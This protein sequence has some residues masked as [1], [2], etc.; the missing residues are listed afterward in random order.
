MEITVVEGKYI[1]KDN[2]LLFTILDQDYGVALINKLHEMAAMSTVDRA[3]MILEKMIPLLPEGVLRKSN[4]F[5]NHLFITAKQTEENK[6]KMG[7]KH[8]CVNQTC[9]KKFYDFHKNFYCPICK[10]PLSSVAV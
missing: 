4:N 7:A 9:N 10:T 3:F 8:V 1:L 6:K 2:E 5:D